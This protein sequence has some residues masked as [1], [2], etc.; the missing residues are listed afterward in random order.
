MVHESW[1]GTILMVCVNLI[2]N[3]VLPMLF[4]VCVFLFAFLWLIRRLTRD[5]EE[6]QKEMNAVAKERVQVE[7]EL[8]AVQRETN[9]LLK[10]IVV[11]LK[12]E[13]ESKTE[14]PK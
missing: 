7:R 8:L 11:K 9:D 2:M 1:K 10:E 6:M 14:G 4:L 3:G 12:S 5:A 13:Q